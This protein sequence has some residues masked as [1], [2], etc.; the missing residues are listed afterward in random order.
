MAVTGVAVAGYGY[1]GGNLTRNVQAVAD[2]ALVGIVESSA[3]RRRAAEVAHP[4]VVIWSSLADALADARVEAVVIATP[5]R[6]H[7]Q[8]ALDVLSA[9]RHVLVEKPLAMTTE[10]AT[11][12]EQ[13]A[14]AANLVAMVG[15]TFLYSMP[16]R[17]LRE[18]LQEGRIGDVAY[19]YSQRL[20][21]GRIRSDCDALWNFA[22]HDIA[23]MLYL[24]DE[25][26][27]EVS[28]RGFS[29]L[30]QG[31]D[32]V[33]FASLTFESGI[34]GHL[35]VSW[36]DPRKVR[37]M[38]VVGSTGMAV[39]DDVSVD[40]KLSLYDSAAVP[41]APEG[42]QLSLGEHQWQTRAGDLHMPKLSLVEPLYQEIAD[43]VRCCRTGETPVASARH[44]VE[45]VRTLEAIDA[46]TRVGGMPVRLEW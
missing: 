7:A 29:F 43:F 39:Y 25:R 40:H 9:G 12:V 5:A 26:P 1:W 35:H 2:S 44:G 22:P 24:L 13:A 11:K 46:S 42:P 14:E 32:D 10:D 21:L 6:S 34:G 17:R 8:L 4:D 19:L 41:S 37:L 36:M 16:V 33:S 28:A 30:Q 20:N 3:E 38:T 18:Y 15:H 45:V 27:A 31:I 23:I